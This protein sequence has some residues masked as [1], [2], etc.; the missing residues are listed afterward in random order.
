[1][2]IVSACIEQCSAV[3]CYIEVLI[4]IVMPHCYAL[5]MTILCTHMHRTGSLDEGSM[6]GG[7][8]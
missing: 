4:C 5:V 3:Q 6:G 8:V 7:A 1:M 2:N